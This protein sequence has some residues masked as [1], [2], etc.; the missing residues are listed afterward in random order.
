MA[1]NLGC[2]GLKEFT[3][4]KSDLENRDFD[5]AASDMQNSYWCGQ[6]GLRC[7]RDVDCVKNG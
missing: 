5:A 1:F 6:V 4:F 7:S 3:T 2:G